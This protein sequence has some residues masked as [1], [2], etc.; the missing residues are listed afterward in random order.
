MV[1]LFL[2]QFLLEIAEG[3][4]KPWMRLIYGPE[5][6]KTNTFCFTISLEKRLKK[7]TDIKFA[8]QIF[9]QK[10]HQAIYNWN[11]IGA[12]DR[13]SD[14]YCIDIA[15]YPPGRYRVNL[16]LANE[17]TSDYIVVHDRENWEIPGQVVIR[18][19]CSFE[20]VERGIE[21]KQSKRYLKLGVVRTNTDEKFTFSYKAESMNSKQ[22]YYNQY[23]YT[24][25]AEGVSHTDVR[26]GLNTTPQKEARTE[27]EV[28]L[29][30]GKDEDCG[31]ATGNQ[32]K[33]IV[34]VI[35][36]LEWQYVRF[37]EIDH[38]AFNYSDRCALFE[39][40]RSHADG[41]LDVP[42]E[43]TRV[44]NQRI[45]QEGIWQRMSGHVKFL[46]GK[47]T[48]YIQFDFPAKTKVTGNIEEAEIRLYNPRSNDSCVKIDAERHIR[49]FSIRYVESEIMDR[50]S[51]SLQRGA[52]WMGSMSGTTSLSSFYTE[53]N[54]GQRR[55]ESRRSRKSSSS[56]GSDVANRSYKNV[57]T[58]SG[59]IRH[60]AKIISVNH[61]EVTW[62]KISSDFIQGF[63]I[64][65]WPRYKMSENYS[66]YV[67][68]KTFTCIIEL[69]EENTEYEILVVPET[70]SRPILRFALDNRFTDSFIQ[71]L[72]GPKI[73]QNSSASSLSKLNNSSSSYRG[74][75]DLF[76]SRSHATENRMITSS[77]GRQQQVGSSM[78]AQQ[79]MVRESTDFFEQSKMITK[80]SS[81]GKSK[82]YG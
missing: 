11:G 23:G 26:I 51:M 16:C 45:W 7:Q 8:I 48:A 24:S 32:N 2:Q 77:L 27:F 67:D 52:K 17:H 71:S 50:G 6:Q 63:V 35:N 66:K 65:W 80:S 15:D 4:R 68:N 41:P 43:A 64:I 38:L 37:T 12:K 42:W 9:G 57:Q 44:D 69:F 36:D 25:F 33:V 19:P 18:K 53:K 74:S 59:V 34:T 82:T 47:Y 13:V 60:E 72:I 61:A 58:L 62:P 78:G 81:G 75:Q 46:D 28:V 22:N 5:I 10:Q 56:S 49:T 39:V 79:R 55:T 14:Q 30:D 76:E 1:F 54:R 21:I 3:T 40:T 20:W 31:C 73:L 70:A 29:L